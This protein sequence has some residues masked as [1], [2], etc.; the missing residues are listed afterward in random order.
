M[1]VLIATI[2]S[3]LLGTPILLSSSFLSKVY[4]IITGINPLEISHKSFTKQIT[5]YIDS[6]KGRFCSKWV[7]DQKTHVLCKVSDRLSKFSPVVI[8][9]GTGSCSFNFCEFMETFPETHDVYCIDLP[10][11]GISEGPL[12]DFDWLTPDEVFKYYGKMIS[13]IL[14][15]LGHSSGTKYT[16]VGHSFGSFILLKSIKLGFIPSSS[17]EKCT[18]CCLPGLIP[19]TCKYSYLWG[20]F[21]I[22]GWLESM[23]KQFWSPYLFRAFLFCDTDP[24]S[25][26][27]TLY[28]YLPNANGYYFVGKHMEFRGLLR[29][30]WVN[31]ICDDLM[32]ITNDNNVELIGGLYDTIV[33]ISPM[34]NNKNYELHELPGGHSLFAQKELFPELLSIIIGKVTTTKSNKKTI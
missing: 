27:K 21:F 12:F 29:P 26:L 5:K 20:T 30:V 16:F 22:T 4:S 11:W 17:V 32:A 3:A 8:L 7:C 25:I 33:D 34:R 18:L 19:L 10:G 15:E 2:I 23:T 24:L 6:T 14:T 1:F 9:H 31:L 13:Q 28:R